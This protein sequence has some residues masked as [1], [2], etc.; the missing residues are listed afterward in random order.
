MSDHVSRV[1]AKVL[2]G[3]FAFIGELEIE[4]A[5]FIGLA[6][7]RFK[8]RVPLP[9]ILALLA[10]VAGCCSRLDAV[11]PVNVFRDGFVERGV[12]FGQLVIVAPAGIEVFHFPDRNRHTQLCLVR[13]RF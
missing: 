12:L 8:Q 9:E 3:P 1:A 4:V 5:V 2:A 6:E 7:V 10:R 13:V 11:S